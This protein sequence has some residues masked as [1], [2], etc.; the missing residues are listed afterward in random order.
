[1]LVL[2]QVAEA[3][4]APPHPTHLHTFMLDSTAGL[5]K[6]RFGT[7]V[8]CPPLISL[9]LWHRDAPQDGSCHP[10][11]PWTRTVSL[12]SFCSSLHTPGTHWQEPGLVERDR[13]PGSEQPCRSPLLLGTRETEEGI[14]QI[15]QKAD[16]L[17]KAVGH[18]MMYRS[19]SPA[20]KGCASPEPGSVKKCKRIKSPKG[21]NQQ[22]TLSRKV[23][24]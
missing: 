10:S 13:F 7:P 16:Y 23:S 18:R 8:Q 4:P 14:S 19:T 22:R 9:A 15:L 1:M 21:T 5:C 20:L 6:H 24:S 3:L 2:S 12:F 17:S 11:R